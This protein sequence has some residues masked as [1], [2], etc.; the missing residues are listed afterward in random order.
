MFIFARKPNSSV[1]FDGKIEELAYS[2]NY[3]MVMDG[4]G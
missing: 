1:P 4:L 2:V 3:R